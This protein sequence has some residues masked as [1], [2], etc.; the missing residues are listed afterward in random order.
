MIKGFWR[1]YAVDL[2]QV[3]RKLGHSVREPL[4]VP[5]VQ[6][7]AEV[8]VRGA[9]GLRHE[10]HRA[11]ARHLSRTNHR[12]APRLEALEEEP[13]ICVESG[14]SQ[15]THFFREGA[16]YLNTKKMLARYARVPRTF[17]S[18]EFILPTNESPR[19]ITSDTGINVALAL[20]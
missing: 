19:S 9:C 15:N 8:A 7:Y 4:S 1:S 18:R 3:L 17:I 11:E 16:V 13:W 2:G 6:R 10:V 20:L 5:S 14:E 12:H